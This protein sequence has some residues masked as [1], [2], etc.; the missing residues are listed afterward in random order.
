MVGLLSYGAGKLVTNDMEKAE[1][2]NAFFA[3]VSTNK[4][5]LQEFQAPETRR[6]VWNLSSGGSDK[7]APLVLREQANAIAR[8]LLILSL[9]GHG[10]EMFW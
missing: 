5:S 8:P 2:L 3:S 6:E 10:D 7:G 9:N 1:V 4:T